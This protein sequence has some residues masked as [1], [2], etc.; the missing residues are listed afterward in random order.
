MKSSSISFLNL[1]FEKI[2]RVKNP[3]IFKPLEPVLEMAKWN[4][5]CRFFNE[6]Y[7]CDTLT[8]EGLK[9]CSECKFQSEFSHKILIIKLGALGDVLRTTPILEAIKQKY[10]ESLIYW[11]TLE[12]SKEILENNPYIDKIL[13]Y[14]LE[15]TLRIQQEHFDI[16][17][18]LEIDTPATL[19]ANLVK[20][21]EKLGFFF[22]EGATSCYNKSGEEYLETAFLTHRKLENRKTYQQ[23]I[24]QACNLEYKKEEPVLELSNQEKEF[25][26]KFWKQE[27]VNEKEKVLGINFSSGNRWQSKSWSNKQVIELIKKLKNW[28]IILLGGKSEQ[29]K[30]AEIKK[31]INVIS[32]PICS[33]KEFAAIMEKC[34]KIITTDSLALHLATSLKK[35]TIALF[36]STPEWEIESYGRIKKLQSPLLKKYFFSNKASEELANSITA[37]EVLKLI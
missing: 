11:L 14:N 8:Q 28:K 13:T 2:L 7:A 4:N 19:L 18:S 31:Q 9:S 16:L 37:D 21:K 32:N 35:P 36:F 5:K 27:K 30:I 1:K 24:F 3:Q 22:E 29:E 15:N 17:Y 23:L 10:P 20:A 25:A 33:I 6:K 12:E 34:E 26:S